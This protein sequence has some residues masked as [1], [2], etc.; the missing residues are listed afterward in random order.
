MA[1]SW[2]LE[3]FHNSHSK[4]ISARSYMSGIM[5]WP[6][7]VLKEKCTFIM[8]RYHQ[9][10]ILSIKNVSKVMRDISLG[11]VKP[12]NDSSTLSSITHFKWLHLKNYWTLHL[13]FTHFLR[14]LIKVLACCPT[15]P[16]HDLN[17]CGPITN[18][19]L[20]HSPECIST[21]AQATFP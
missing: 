6:C 20:W 13:C 10:T 3:N 7:V 12:W 18:E 11:K 15:A 1:C 8:H 16:R 14:R 19:V 21:S 2:L 5:L 17:Q 9:L 4:G